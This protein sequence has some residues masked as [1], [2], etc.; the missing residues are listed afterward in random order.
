MQLTFKSKV[1]SFD[2]CAG[3]NA[4]HKVKATTELI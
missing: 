2:D 4:I 3:N 1:D